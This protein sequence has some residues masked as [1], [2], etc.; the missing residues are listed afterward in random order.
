MRKNPILVLATV[1]LSSVC[2]PIT[3][4]GASIAL[5]PI[6]ADLGADLAAV[7]WVVNG[8]N[9]TFAGFMLAG[10]SLADLFGRRRVY[11]AGVGLFAAGGL[12]SAFA[13]DILLLNLA[14]AA[15]GIGAAAA[16]AAGGALLA[17]S[18]HGAA[19]T[20]VFGL[21]GTTLGLGLAFG[22]S[23]S[24]L[25]V[26]AYGWR[27][28]FGSTAVAGLLVLFLVPLLPESRDPGDRRLDLP[29]MITFTGALVL[30]IAGFVEGP[31]LG[32]DSPV[33]LTA[34]AAFAVLFTAFVVIERRAAHPMLDLQ[35][36]AGRRF[37]GVS[38]AAGAIVC[39]LVPLLVYLP[40]YLT[41]VLGMTPGQAGITLI[42]LTGP[43]LV[44]PTLTGLAARWVP[45][46]A[47][48]LAAVA[49][50]GVGAVWLTTIGP[51]ASTA[52]IAG[53]MLT[54][55][56]GMGMSIGLVDGIAISSAP[57]GRVGT[58]GG[59]FNTFRLVSE[60][61]AIAVFGAVI[62]AVTG[63]R[64]AGPAFTDGMHAVLW[65][66]AGLSL[67]TLVA[68]AVLLR[69]GPSGERREEPAGDLAVSP[70]QDGAGRT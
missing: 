1:L 29:G 66:M 4:T 13:G 6:T 23:I 16:G 9:A 22:P 40:S 12:V 64:L 10:G 41:A 33:V 14:R 56:A 61:I 47:I 27:A 59:M 45:P 44:L 15:A 7:Q 60:T 24:G 34:F 52:S 63:D 18:F 65:S 26:D 11:A 58:A 32:W 69:P 30:L 48:V 37:L 35:L 21:F 3:L 46:S 8:Y 53:P 36:L 39:V 67:V 62:A 57:A 55:G 31:S 2:L 25:I 70:A 54:I 43:T 50:S 51:G 19:R 5:S 20:R 49:L 42:V 28:V 38:L 17:A 68:V